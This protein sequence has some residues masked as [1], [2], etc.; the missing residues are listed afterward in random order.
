MWPLLVGSKHILRSVMCTL[1]SARLRRVRPTFHSPLEE[2]LAAAAGHDPVVASRGL[3]RTH[4]TDLMSLPAGLGLD[5]QGRAAGL[6][7][8]GRRA[9]MYTGGG[10]KIMFRQVSCMQI[11][12]CV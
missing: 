3:V 6:G 12:R 5:R 4:Q 2:H 9:E 10:E 7:G 8:S 11:P 1:V